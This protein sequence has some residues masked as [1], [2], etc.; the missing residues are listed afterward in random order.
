MRRCTGGLICP[1]QAVE[2][3]RHFVSRRAFDIEGLGD[4]QIEAFFERAGSRSRPTSSRLKRA[5]T[6]SGSR[7]GRGRRVGAQSL[8]RHRGAPD[9]ALD[10]FIFAL[11][12]RHVGETNA[13]LIARH[14]GSIGCF[15]TAS[16]GGGRPRSEAWEELNAINGIGEI[17]ADSLVDFFDEPPNRDA[18]DRLLDQVTV[19]A[20]EAARSFAGRRQDR[21]LHR[22]AREDD[23][24]RGQ[25]EGRAPR[26]QGRGLGVDEDRLCRRRPRAG[27]KEKARE[28]GVS[29][30]SEDE[31]FALVGER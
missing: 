26:R 14:Y 23:A 3:L 21:G 19:T 20:M 24:R 28:L 9:V 16:Q 13:K 7:S 6:T 10:R 27:S 2:R 12:I 15:A 31:W 25:G 1:A 4:K 22:H 29:L 8:R 11:G 17:V 18:V 5:A 30:L